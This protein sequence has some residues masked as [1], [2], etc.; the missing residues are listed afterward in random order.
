MASLNGKVGPVIMPSFMI[1]NLWLCLFFQLFYHAL[2][3]LRDTVMNSL[4]PSPHYL[5]NA[6]RVDSWQTVWVMSD[7]C[8]HIIKWKWS[9]TLR[10]VSVPHLKAIRT[11]V[12]IT[13][14]LEIFA[15]RDTQGWNVLSHLF[16]SSM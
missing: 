13:N 15:L 1:F 10:G 5:I 16:P 2:T 4:Q 12:S 3:Y 8:G 7:S 6:C 9:L 14:I 11:L